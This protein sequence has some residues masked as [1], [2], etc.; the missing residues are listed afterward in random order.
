MTSFVPWLANLNIKFKRNV[1]SMFVNKNYRY[2]HVQRIL[3]PGDLNLGT[4]LTY[5]SD[6]YVSFLHN[7]N[8]SQT[9]IENEDYYQ[10]ERCDPDVTPKSHDYPSRNSM[11]LVERMNVSIVE[12]NGLILV[13]SESET[14]KKPFLRSGSSVGFKS[15]PRTIN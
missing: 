15:S 8:V 13:C 11:V 10:L 9:G 4:T 14:E 12:M 6:R 3:T 5:R 7:F 1:T 2:T